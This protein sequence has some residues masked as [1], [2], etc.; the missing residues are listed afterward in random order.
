M[1][2]K[3]L[4][5]IKFMYA[6]SILFIALNIVLII[7]D[8]YWLAALPL[9][10]L[11]IMMLFFSLDKLLLL[12][13]AITPF[14]FTYKNEEMGFSVDIPTEPL[15]VLIMI[16]FFLKL[17]YERQFERSVLKHPV[18]IILGI[19]L[20][21]LFITSV[22]SEIPVVSFKFFLSRLWFVVVFYFMTIRFFKDREKTRWF[23]W[24]FAV[25]LAILV[26]Y[27]TFVH[28][29][30]GFERFAGIAAVRPFFNDHTNYGA[31]LA[32]VAPLFGV[33]AFYPGYKKIYRR[34][35]L[36][37]FILFAI[38]IL[39]SYSRASWLS[40]AVAFGVM[41]ILVMKINFK[42]VIAAF[43][44]IAGF[45]F[46]H[47]EQ[48]MMDLQ[49]NTQESSGDISEHVKSISNITSDAS[50]LE[51]INRWRSAIRMYEERPMFGWG[52]GTYQFV[53]APFQLSTDYTIITT[54]FGDLGNAHSEYL[55]PLSETGLPGMIITF[56]L[57]LAIIALAVNNY[58]HNPNREFRWMS[59]GILLGYVAYFTHGLLNNFL[60][61]DKVS[62][63]FWSFLAILVA[64]N[65]F[66]KNKIETKDQENESNN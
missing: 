57:F 45:F 28:S 1:S 27:I 55:G 38:G 7:N 53:Y 21:W 14:A 60:D 47:Q 56:A 46:Y 52:P 8:H 4:T 29:L 2:L 61:T 66:H 12:V 32:L 10:L 11:V 59:L 25:P 22:T 39:L 33:M 36:V 23:P 30:S 41:M 3:I 18:T 34:I 49:R 19:Q 16:V 63:P 24:V 31:T 50:N 40:L 48:I 54:H 17:I 37:I 43:L 51:R 62:V 9:G 64:I 5:Q 6:V 65:I 26:I 44:I 20:L 13:V 58:K 15:I 35:A 42:L